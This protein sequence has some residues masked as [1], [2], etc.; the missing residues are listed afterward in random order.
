MDPRLNAWFTQRGWRPFAYQLEAWAAY[1]AGDSGLIH[2]PTGVGKT[3]AAWLGPV[4]E[5]L[6]DQPVNAAHPCNNPASAANRPAAERPEG[7]ARRR[8]RAANAAQRQRAVPIRVLWITPLRALAG[9]T[10]AALREPVEELGLPWLVEHRMGDTPAGVKQRQRERLPTALVT[11]PESLSLLISYPETHE[12][13]RSLRC[14]V[15]DEWHE[16]M[17]TKRGVQTELCLA[18]LRAWLPELRVWGLSATL[19]NLREARDVLL[20]PRHDPRRARLIE[21]DLHKQVEVRT[22]IPS[23]VD[24]FPWAGHLGARLVNEVAAAIEQART[25]LLFTNTRSQAEIWFRTLMRARPD[26]VGQV[27]LHH[28]SL[29]RALRNRVEELLKRGALRAVVCTA[30]LDLGVDFSPVEQVVQLGSPKGIARLLQRAG[31]SGHQPGATSRV[32]CVP[33]HAF[34][35][36][37]FAAARRALLERRVE[38][39]PPLERPMDVLAQHLVTVSLAAPFDAAQLLHEVRG[40]HAFR[41]LSNDAWSWALEF[42][43]HGGRSLTAYPQYARIVERDGLYHVRSPQI[44]RQHR[45]AIGT[46]VGDSGVRVRTLSGRTLGTIEESFISRL[47]EGERFVFAGKLLELVMLRGVDAIVRAARRGDGRVPRWSGGRFPLS[48]QLGEAVRAH[49]AAGCSPSTDSAPELTAAAPLLKL[50]SEWSRVPGPGEILVEYVVD[51]SGYH[52]CM[53]P[54]EG[55]LVHEGLA[56][57]VAERLTQRRSITL[58][59]TANDYGFEL[60]SEVPLELTG[61]DWRTLLG[62]HRLVDDLLACVNSTQMARRQ[63]RDIARVAGLIVPGFPGARRPNRHLQASSDMFFDVFRDFD[64]DSLLL[65]QARREVLEQQLELDRLRRT[66][67]RIAAQELVL[68]RPERLTPLSFPL[69]AER[70]RAQYVS[71]ERWTQ[72]VQ[73]MAL[74]LERAAGTSPRRRRARENRSEVSARA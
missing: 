49:L 36:I 34:E 30:S 66:L 4:G 35:L 33:T 71:S 41:H 21:C 50:Q 29:D 53:F 64:P 47:G 38:S 39:R 20:G 5:W 60:L 63:F 14:V 22:I 42:A 72:R 2:T 9:D 69:S 70:L 55:R 57:L 11:T 58:N 37:E 13:L 43:T 48:T 68:V 25:T 8:P 61:D 3:L 7:A 18:R 59:L 40:T 32:L 45:M 62:T 24:R 12:N 73:R 65:D 44:A 1:T 46:I 74:Q 16:L 23:Q 10:V 54:F 17:G 6:A 27:A 26:W 51:A 28:G 67:E 52:W 15:V 56:A 19:G 31:R